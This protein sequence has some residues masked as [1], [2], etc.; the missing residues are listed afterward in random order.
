MPD[1]RVNF[2]VSL[3]ASVKYIIF[4]GISNFVF[5]SLNSDLFL[6]AAHPATDVGKFW[7]DSLFKS[8]MKSGYFFPFASASTR[9]RLCEFL[10][11]L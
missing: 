9:N 1:R 7:R 4:L 11:T 6:I 10:L 2:N 3:L 5:I 8:E